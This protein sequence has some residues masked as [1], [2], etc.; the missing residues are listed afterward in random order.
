MFST[1]YINLLNRSDYCCHR[2]TSCSKTCQLSLKKK[3]NH[4]GLQMLTFPKVAVQFSSLMD[5]KNQNIH[6]VLTHTRLGGKPNKW[7]MALQELLSNQLSGYPQ[8]A[9]QGRME[10]IRRHG[11]IAILQCNFHWWYFLTS[12][13]NAENASVQNGQKD[14]VHLNYNQSHI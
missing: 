1:S 14:T 7:Q 2:H 11:S 4:K 13:L 9:T 5:D 6:H 8:C 3:E 10:K 12:L